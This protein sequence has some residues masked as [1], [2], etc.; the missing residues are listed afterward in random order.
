MPLRR[1]GHPALED[2]QDRFPAFDN[3][4]SNRLNRAN[5]L[6]VS[7]LG[8]VSR[9]VEQVRRALADEDRKAAEESEHAKQLEEQA[10]KIADLLNEDFKDWARELARL[11]AA[12]RAVDAGTSVEASVAAQ[13]AVTALPVDRC[14]RL[15]TWTR[16]GS[17]F[18]QVGGKPASPLKGKA[19]SGPDHPKTRGATG[20]P[21]ADDGGGPARRTRP[22]P[23]SRSNSGT[24]SGRVPIAVHPIRRGRSSSISTILS[25]LQPVMRRGGGAGR[26]FQQLS[27]E[28]ALT[29]YAIWLGVDRSAGGRRANLGPY[30]QRSH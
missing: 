22:A 7:L 10:A 9:S 16:R 25:L 4:R 13:D 14:L 29:E 19:P 23:A 5:P 21:G 15:R 18:R 11:Q 30:A 3:T 1:S 17:D 20:T 6:V 8:W 26:S 28:I 2:D 24:C 12:T 27:Y